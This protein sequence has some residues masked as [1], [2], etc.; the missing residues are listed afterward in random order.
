MGQRYPDVEASSSELAS[1]RLSHLT[2]LVRRCRL[3]LRSAALHH[4]TTMKATLV[5]LAR[6]WGAG[7]AMLWLTMFGLGVVL[8]PA[9]LILWG[10]DGG[11]VSS[12]ATQWALFAYG[13][14]CA[15]FL[16]YY[17]LHRSQFRSALTPARCFF[18]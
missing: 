12:G 13:L 5:N 4:D 1:G 2:R 10:L 7:L 16:T 18:S 6:I 14:V 17:I 11:H 8:A 9:Y 3:A 15:P